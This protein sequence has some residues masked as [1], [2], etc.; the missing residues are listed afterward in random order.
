MKRLGALLGASALVAALAT[1]RDAHAERRKIVLY[2]DAPLYH[3]VE[4]GLRPWD[5]DI[6]SGAESP[7]ATMPR[8]ADDAAAVAEREHAN[9]VVWISTDTNGE[10]ALWVYDAEQRRVSSRPLHKSPPFDD[11]TAAAI[12]LSVKTLLRLT[13]I[14]PPAERFGAAPSIAPSAPPAE[15]SAPTTSPPPAPAPSHQIALEV[16]LGARFA[17]TDAAVAEP[18]ATI[19]GFYSF[20]KV[21]LGLEASLGPGVA[22]DSTV[23]HARET[24]ATFALHA[25]ARLGSDRLV[26]LPELGPGA[27]VEI[28]D[29]AYA[30]GGV[31]TLRLDPAIDLGGTLAYALSSRAYVGIHASASWLLRW[32]RFEVDGARV[33][34]GSPIVVDTGLRLGVELP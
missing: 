31:H 16:T 29:G 20:G 2:G 8:A 11:A 15:S 30:S 26:V 13:T 1:T 21:S 4:V 12:A 3:A 18:R 14:A 10:T 6:A 34:G 32:Q 25:R 7:G 5:V 19:G 17:Q 27:H 24:D 33:L 28:V 23:F 22:V 9:G